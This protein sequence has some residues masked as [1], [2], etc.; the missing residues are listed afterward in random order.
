MV[1]IPLV[2]LKAQYSIL[3]SEIE[4]AV[5]SVL[6]RCD[7]IMGAGV[8]MFE[9][10]FAEFTG[11]KFC[12]GVSNG[13][14]A[15]HLALLACGIKN[16]D[17]VVTVPN[18]FIATTEA[19][20][21][22]GARVVFA[23]IDSE[24][25]TIDVRQIK[26]KIT[27]KTKAII[28]VHLYGLPADMDTIMKI[29]K[30]EGLFVIEDAAQAHGAIYK[31]MGVGV[32]GDIGCFSFYPGK[33]L[34]AYGDA[35]AIVTN[36]EEFANKIKLLRDHGRR[37]KY[38]HEIEGFNKR[39]DT[40]QAAVLRIKLKYL[41]EWNEKRRKNAEIYSYALKDIDGV[42]VP[43]KIKDIKS[44]YHLYVIKAK[45]RDNLKEYLEKEGIATGIHYPIPLHLQSAYKYLGLKEGN[46]PVAED[47]AKRILSLPMYP[48]LSEEQIYYISEKIKKFYRK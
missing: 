28:P 40:L 30:D 24:S 7:F 27:K 41:K 43:V 1:K 26:N 37:K 15:I 45:D 3:K 35:G 47:T 11:G 14:D 10:E 9:E 46:F 34:G 17:E 36:N 22:T 25:Y 16:G 42:E 13:T 18:T 19:I 8:S 33:N 29:A 38:E 20:T 31:D 44:V 4:P 23:D 48:E 32:I 39:I 2:D 6:D 5:K 12:I 21:M